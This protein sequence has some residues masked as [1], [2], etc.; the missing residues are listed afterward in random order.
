MLGP[1]IAADITEGVYRF[2]ILASI[3]WRPVALTVD[4][5]STVTTDNSSLNSCSSAESVSDDVIYVE[6]T[7]EENGERETVLVP[8]CEGTMNPN[9]VRKKLIMR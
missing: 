5:D 2:R 9:P 8:H 7:I 4:S 3:K 6:E 1:I